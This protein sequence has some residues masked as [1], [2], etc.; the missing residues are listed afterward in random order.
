MP[1]AVVWE[2][3][4]SID[5]D[6]ITA[7]RR[8]I[9]GDGR[10]GLALEEILHLHLSCLNGIGVLKGEVFLEIAA[11]ASLGKVPEGAGGDVGVRHGLAEQVQIL[12]EIV[13]IEGAQAGGKVVSAGGGIGSARSHVV[14]VV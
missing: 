11:G 12:R 6:G 7:L 1:Y 14:V 8:H 3:Q 4:V 13:G 5:I 2:A 9:V 10:A